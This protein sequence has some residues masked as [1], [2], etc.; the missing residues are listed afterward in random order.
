MFWA[1]IKYS[2]ETILMYWFS[3]N[4]FLLIVHPLQDVFKIIIL[5]RTLTLLISFGLSKNI[6]HWRARVFPNGQYNPTSRHLL[7]LLSIEPVH[8]TRRFIRRALFGA[9]NP[10]FLATSLQKFFDFLVRAVLSLVKADP[11]SA[12]CILDDGV[13]GEG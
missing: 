13:V 1:M 7:F 10:L 4:T 3:I 8:A 11:Q 9:I 5:F 12:R 6:I 2:R